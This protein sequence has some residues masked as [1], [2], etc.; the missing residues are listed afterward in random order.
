MDDTLRRNI[1]LGR[2]ADEI[3]EGR[4]A[5]CIG[6]AQLADVVEQLP[7]GLDTVLG[8]RGIRLSGGQ[9]QRVAIARALYRDPPVL[10]LD[11]GTSALDTATE[12]ALVSAL[13]AAK[14][15][16]TLVA[17]AHRISTLRDADRILVVAGGGIADAG[18]YDELWERSALFRD[19]AS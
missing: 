11:E 10:V 12:A 17:V 4:L 2:D 8:E 14:G 3:D 1:A 13:D 18:T 16:R 5:A 15:R 7:D 6:I 19:L 9:R